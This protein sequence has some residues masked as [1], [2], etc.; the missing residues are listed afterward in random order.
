MNAA[1]S[2]EPDGGEPL[3]RLIERQRGEP[4][5]LTTFLQVATNLAVALGH[6]H[7]QGLI[8]RDVKPAN[9]C[10]DGAGR[11]RLS[12]GDTALRSRE[13]RASAPGEASPGTLA[14]MA[15]E[16]TGRMNRSL[17]ARSDLYSLGITLYELLTG[18]PPF[19]ASEPMELIHCHIARPPAPPSLRMP[20]VPATIDA[21]V[22]KLLAKNPEDRY[23]SAAGV[24]GDLRT[25]AA[26]YREH[27]RIPPFE[28]ATSD[29]SDRLTVPEKLYGRE[30]EVA[31]LNAAL[32]RVVATGESEVVLVAGYSG[33]GKSALAGELQRALLPR[34]GLFVAGKHEQ[35]KRDIPHATLAQAFQGLV[36]Q[37]L[38][39]SDAELASWREALLAALGPSGQL[40]VGMIPELELV[41][42]EQP[43]LAEVEPQ[44]A[45]NRFYQAFRSLVGVFARPGQPLVLF[46]DDLQWLDA[47]TLQ[48]VERLILEPDAHNLLVVGAYRD[49]EVDAAHPLSASLRAV[50][51]AGAR[52]SEIAL[53]PLRAPQLAELFADVLHTGARRTRE[54]AALVA[55]KTGGNP[56]FAIQ[57]VTEL[58]EDGLLAFDRDWGGWR[59]DVRRIRARGITDNVAELMAG[60]LARLSPEARGTLAR[61]A[62]LGN[63]VDAR[64][65]SCTAGDSEE[66]VHARL[67]EAVEAGLIVQA[68]RGFGF[69]HDR[70]HEAAYALIPASERAATH[71]RLG[72]ALR[73]LGPSKQRED[74]IFDV[75]HQYERGLSALDADAERAQV[76]ELYLLAGVRAK[77]S[78]AYVAAHA[79]LAAGRALLGPSSWQAHYQLTLDFGRNLAECE[80][81][82]GELT[83]AEAR[84]A[85]LS[86]HVEGV[87]ER[88]GIVCLTVLLYFTTARSLRACEVALAFLAQSGITWPLRPSEQ[89]VRA[90]YDE[91]TQRLAA[92]STARQDLPEMRAPGAIAIMDVLT[93]LF[94]AAYAVDRHL[95]ELVVLRMT[96]LSLAEGLCESSSVAFAALN[97]A[98]GAHYAASRTAFELGQVGCALVERRA[99]SRF[100]ARVY[101]LYAAFTMPWAQH[102]PLC[103]PLMRQ[104]FE[105]GS[106]MGDM[107]FAAYNE[108]NLIT[109]LLVSGAPLAQVQRDAE[110]ATAF[111]RRLQLGLGAEQF[112]RQLPLILRLR[113]L[114]VADAPEDD[115]WARQ[116]IEDQPQLGMMVCYHWVFRL[117]ECYFAGELDEALDAAARIEPIRWAM[118]SSIEEA[119]YDFY[120]ALTRAAASDHAGDEAR[121]AHLAALQ[122]HHGRI[123]RWA[124]HCPENFAN[125]RALIGAERARL[126]GRPLDAQRLYEEAV[127]SARAYGFT[128][129]EA[130]ASELAGTWYA[131]C[132]LET[133]A[134]AYL[135]NARAC[136]ERWGALSKLAQLDALHPQLRVQEGAGGAPTKLERPIAQLDV[137]TVDKASQTLSSEMVLPS[138]LEKLVRLAVEHAGA[139]R[140][141]L[142]LQRGGELHIE[143]EAAV[144]RGAVQVVVQRAR[145]HATDLPQSALQYVLR[146]RER[147]VLDDASRSGLDA[148][149]EY[150]RQNRPRSVLCLPVFKQMQVVGALYLENNLTPCAFTADRVAVLDFLASQAAIALENARLYSDL[151]RS[152]ALLKEAQHLSSTGSFCWH[153]SLDTL[154]F[155]EQTFRIYDLDPSEPVTLAMLAERVH[156][157]DRALWRELID[158]AR[159]PT[160]DL[161]C[162]YRVQLPDATVKHLHLVA[163]GARDARG[164]LEYIGAIQ[165]VTQRQLAEEALSKV[166]AE[167]A[168][169]ARI[170]SLGVLTASIAHEVSQ[171]L[172]GIVTNA[173]TCLRMLDASPPNVTGARETVRRLIRDG[174]RAS[175]VITRL[176]ALF[177]NKDATAEAVDLNE[178]T[179]EVLSLS[180][181]EL[182]SVRVALRTELAPD[183]P[184]VVGDRVQLQQVI[185]NLLL[186]AADAMSSVEDR[187]RTL[188]IRTE[189]EGEDVVRLSVEDAGVGFDPGQVDKLF[190]AFYSTKADGMGMGLSVS[191]SIIESHHGSLSAAPNVGRPGATFAF[192]LPRAP[193][194]SGE[195]S[196]PEASSR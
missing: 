107:A 35:F 183:L 79:Y 92:R 50:R 105:I 172:S 31:L 40:M 17:D 5:D 45:Q 166:R 10:V 1:L 131:A 65:L 28:L 140:G 162:A 103:Q 147:L 149:D 100:K 161:D 190:E 170:T 128:Q 114:P 123:T 85:E 121:A 122:T 195:A 126:E 6:V 181:S 187:A 119:E 106:A 98:L 48:L 171:P 163:H 86:Q 61:L 177:G 11:V 2:N 142:I 95:M 132:G 77:T 116:D 185:L 22:L 133:V 33:T 93:E 110:H 68:E 70:V 9:V 182:Q 180:R 47:A 4:L 130:L 112:I 176:R 25:C 78:S 188:V 73:A 192:S 97:M 58:A 102:L 109:H 167:L 55:E 179:R 7:R 69:V 24:E 94:P 8:H 184:P 189:A 146:T 115:A 90:E 145:V 49:N 36:R 13:L 101:S 125:R 196:S 174:N 156:P 18:K 175:E 186:N 32:E 113:G 191:R 124:E 63:V 159:G 42:G 152:E 165:D 51:A 164:E 12:G 169:V 118:R 99:A 62:C 14:Y 178:T 134:L 173:S 66:D 138:L 76:A 72:R 89:D 144:V 148:D 117:E 19:T 129:N 157:E 137:Q 127:Q 151:Q 41:I 74:R 34:R 38:S 23:R 21:I 135:R 154:E 193:E 84:L 160:S 141:L 104:A 80:I 26:A 44:S 150:V 75:V 54:L 60:R 53:T 59:W 155:S 83:A 57:F 56:F 29:A 91:M 111:A 43:T 46:I 82:L 139:E 81:V 136:Y 153:V 64:T 39:K 143:A 20:G 88:A 71:L 108:R 52:V 87:T 67:Y 30:V 16:Q 194:A 120:A 168:H 15:P 3:D 37:L 27:G 158:G 96:N